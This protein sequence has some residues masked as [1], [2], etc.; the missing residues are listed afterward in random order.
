MKKKIIY[1]IFLAVVFI[2]AFLIGKSQKEITEVVPENYIL[3]E[4]CIPLEDISY[5]YIDNYGYPCFELKDI[6]NQLDNPN[7]KSYADIM[8][9]ME[10][11]F[12]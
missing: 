2:T 3:I 9:N 10:R 6:K 4:E 7:N 11:D 8:S 12:N 5:Y 1:F